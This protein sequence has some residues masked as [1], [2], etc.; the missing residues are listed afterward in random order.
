MGRGRR[1]RRQRQ[2]RES[3]TWRKAPPDDNDLFMP[4]L[5]CLTKNRKNQH[6][7]KPRPHDPPRHLSE[8]KKVTD[9][10]KIKIFYRKLPKLA[11][12]QIKEKNTQNT[13]PAYTLLTDCTK[14]DG[15]PQ[16]T[17]EKAKL[18]TWKNHMTQGP[19]RRQR[20]IYSC[21]NCVA[22]QRKG[23]ISTAW[24]PVPVTHPTI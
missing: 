1:E 16:Q 17:R 8:Q 4:Q 5:C 3:T 10:R 12:M 20:S 23:R 22:K 24:K 15:G 2:Q 6:S 9:G 21:P 11:G 14:K 18:A 7:M 19:T 13:Q